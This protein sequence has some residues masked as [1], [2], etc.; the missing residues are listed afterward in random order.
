MSSFVNMVQDHSA[1]TQQSWD[2]T[3]GL[4]DARA[5]VLSSEFGSL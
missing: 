5:D 2:S 1:S 3:P 4:S